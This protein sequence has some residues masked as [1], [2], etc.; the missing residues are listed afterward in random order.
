MHKKNEVGTDCVSNTFKSGTI[1][2]PEMEI[3]QV[4]LD[5]ETKQSSRLL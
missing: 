1:M 4:S 5:K 3:R 2:K